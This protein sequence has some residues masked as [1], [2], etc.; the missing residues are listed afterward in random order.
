MGK[1]DRRLRTIAERVAVVAK[2]QA[3]EKPGWQRWLRVLRI[4]LPAIERAE[5]TPESV[6]AV[7]RMRHSIALLEEYGANEPH[8]EPWVY[9]E[10]FC[11]AC[12]LR[13]SWPGFVP[14]FLDP[15]YDQQLQQVVDIERGR[16]RLPRTGANG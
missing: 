16:H 2:E 13:M 3:Q 12:V 5:P 15:K 6:A 8:A 14:A 9:L 7:E 11:H 4:F 1:L 10:Y